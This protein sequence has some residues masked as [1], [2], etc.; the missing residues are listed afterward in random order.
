MPYVKQEQRPALDTTMD[1]LIDLIKSLPVEEQDGALNYAL[2]RMLKSVYP[3]RYFHFNRALGVLA[4]VTHEF[5]R[6]VVGPYEDE[7]IRENG[8]VERR[9]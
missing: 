4:A 9:R 6:A 7:K 2:T 8:P 3:S 5:Y 1:P